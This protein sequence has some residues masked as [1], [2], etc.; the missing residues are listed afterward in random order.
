MTQYCSWS[1]L[2]H[3]RSGTVCVELVVWEGAQSYQATFK[4]GVHQGSVLCPFLFLFYINDLPNTLRSEVRLF[5]D[6]TDYLSVSQQQDAS[7]LQQDLKKWEKKW[8]M[9]F[10]PG[11]CQVLTFTRIHV[12]VYFEY[13]LHGLLLENVTIAKY[14]GVIFQN[15]MHFTNHIN[16]MTSSATG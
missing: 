11:K 4:S 16:K 2:L 6:D 12:P 10:H 14:L 15:N 13:K 9:E 7:I 8:G 3:V 5:A 1:V